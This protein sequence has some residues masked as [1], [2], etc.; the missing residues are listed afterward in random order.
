MEV[1]IPMIEQSN[2]DGVHMIYDDLIQESERNLSEKNVEK[3]LQ[4]VISL[5][6]GINNYRKY[7]DSVS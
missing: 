6:A 1:Q 3:A 4:E 5:R 2:I 7:L